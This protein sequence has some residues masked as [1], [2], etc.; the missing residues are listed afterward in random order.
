MKRIFQGN[1]RQWMG[2]ILCALLLF[3]ALGVPYTAQG[4]GAA[5]PAAGETIDPMVRVYLR[6]LGVTDR[7]DVTLSSAYGLSSESGATLYFGAGSQLSFQLKNDRIFLYYDNM[8]LEVGN[9]RLHRY[10]DVETGEIGFRRTHFAPLYIGDLS[11]SVQEGPGGG[12]KVIRPVLSI[13]VE[14]YLLGVVPYEMSD[15]FP[16][17]AL[18]AQTVA[19]RTY[20]LRKRNPKAD[21]DVVDTTNDQVFKGYAAG[22]DRAE[23]AVADT[24]GVCGFYQGK[25]AQCYYAASNGGWTEKLSTVWADQKDLDCYVSRED[26]YD[27]ENP[28]STV[29]RAVFQKAYSNQGKDTAAFGLRNLLAI[30]LGD[31]LVSRGFDPAPESVQVRSVSDVTLELAQKDRA[32]GLPVTLRMTVAVNGRTRTDSPAATSGQATPSPS[33]APSQTPSPLEAMPWEDS[34]ASHPDGATVAP[35]PAP[36][37][38]ASP[39]PVYG[40]FTELEGSFPLTIPVFPTAESAL[41]MN[42]SGN[43]DNEIWTLL[44]TDTAYTLEARRFGHGAGMSQRGAE[45]M[46][47]VYG[48]TYEEILD[49]YYPGLELKRYDEAE[50]P[51]ATAAAEL[52]APAGP[53]PSPTP[54]PTLMPVSLQPSGDQWVALVTGIDDD[55]SLNLRSLP[56][57]SGEVL[58]RLYKNQRLLVLEGC[59][60]DGW[61]KVATDVV[62]GYVMERFLSPEVKEQ[63]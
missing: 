57:T 36:T 10:A 3:T 43:Y 33:L 62:Q 18:K 32:S 34:A 39:V 63:L 46:A 28:S 45:W 13:H 47:G 59:Q 27:V 20:V 26:P 40:P 56:D 21:Y 52:S 6:R 58:M 49:F 51:L 60:E 15:S 25:L 37:P 12:A 4:Q 11:L 35:T 48:K 44:E 23:K 54:R 5:V 41:G 19:A 61:V 14:D 31:E 8:S 50:T 2:G 7:M 9:C 1:R 38:T 42:I 22:F 55:S 30:A 16:L 24:Y 53:A 17:E 29:R